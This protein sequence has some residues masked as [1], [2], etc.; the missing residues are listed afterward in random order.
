[1]PFK[2]PRN[3]YHKGVRSQKPILACKHYQIPQ[4]NFQHNT[5]ITL[6]EKTIKK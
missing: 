4:H 5:K 2:V 6:S 3:I 1:M